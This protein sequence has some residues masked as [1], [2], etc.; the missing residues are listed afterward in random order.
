[1]RGVEV[2]GDR[3]LDSGGVPHT[4]LRHVFHLKTRKTVFKVERI[5]PVVLHM[6]S[7]CRED[8]KKLL[9][10]AGRWPEEFSIIHVPFLVRRILRSRP[11]DFEASGRSL[12]KLEEDRLWQSGGSLRRYG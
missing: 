4:E 8:G 6:F 9:P 3:G 5:S 2:S 12:T 7:T 11:F 1:L 10:R